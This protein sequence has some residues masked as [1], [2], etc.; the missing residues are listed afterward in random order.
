M[1]RKS[2]VITNLLISSSYGFVP[3]L[4]PL[5]ATHNSQRHQCGGNLF[6]EM[7][8][9][10]QNKQM[11]H[12][13]N[14]VTA[15]STESSQSPSSLSSVKSPL[16]ETDLE[17]YDLI[18]KEDHRQKYGL[19]LIASENF[20]SSSVRQAL[21]SC[22]T[23]KY[24]EGNGKYFQCFIDF[25]I[26]INYSIDTQLESFRLLQSKLANDIMVEMSLL[27]KLNHCA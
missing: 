17:L 21:G 12:R 1:N 27:T 2:T 23:N 8:Q 24:S 16:E 15:S 18:Q 7:K 4:L 3:S 11:W 9:I 20:A 5:V 19:E 25:L 22:L 26:Y 13:H 10:I 14:M 6:G